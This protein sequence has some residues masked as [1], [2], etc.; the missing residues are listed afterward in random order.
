M[1]ERVALGTLGERTTSTECESYAK[2]NVFGVHFKAN[3]W[4]KSRCG[5]VV[6][7]LHEGVSRYCVVHKFLRLETKEFA[8]VSWLTKPVYP[9]SPNPLVV[10]VRLMT[11]RRER[12]MCCLVPLKRID[13]T[14]VIVEPENDGEHFYMLRIKGFDRI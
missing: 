6:T 2:A 8:S 7:T 12:E 13:P 5:S 10:R 1:R 14:P 4:S 3:E 11:P 9:Y